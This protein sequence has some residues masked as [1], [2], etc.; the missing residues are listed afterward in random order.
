MMSLRWVACIIANAHAMI[1]QRYSRDLEV[2]SFIEVCRGDDDEFGIARDTINNRLK[3]N[4][5][6]FVK[7]DMI[8][9]TQAFIRGHT[10]HF[11]NPEYEECIRFVLGLKEWGPSA[12]GPSCLNAYTEH[13]AILELLLESGLHPDGKHEPPEIFTAQKEPQNQHA[14]FRFF[15]LTMAVFDMHEDRV[16]M[17][18][19]YG[20][21]AHLIYKEDLD[22]EIVLLDIITDAYS[23]NDEWQNVVQFLLHN[24]A[25]WRNFPAHPQIDQTMNNMMHDCIAVY[26]SLKHGCFRDTQDDQQVVVYAQD[27][28]DRVFAVFQN[29]FNYFLISVFCQVLCSF[30][31]Q[32]AKTDYISKIG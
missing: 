4:Q 30:S 12:W 3:N 32:R 25:V 11:E 29:G 9:Y 21:S 14:P 22:E 16:R 2:E 31:R 5:M 10:V 27:D 24:G 13:D 1:A 17:L 8:E 6:P 19:E 15:A 7:Q 28:V 18:L 20:A 26:F 23:L